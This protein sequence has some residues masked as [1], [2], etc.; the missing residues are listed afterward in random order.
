MVLIQS[1]SM[2]NKLSVCSD[3]RSLLHVYLMT[4]VLKIDEY[5]QI[6]ICVLVYKYPCISLGKLLR[7]DLKKKKILLFILQRMF[8]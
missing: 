2:T 8:S 5:V 4:R 6:K 1:N 7:L 3:K